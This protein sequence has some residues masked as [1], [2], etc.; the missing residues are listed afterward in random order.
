MT[1]W[2]MLLLCVYITLGVGRVSW[3]KSGHIA[4]VI[5]AVVIAAAVVSYVHKAPV[6]KYIRSVDATVYQTG[7]Q[8]IVPGEI[9]HS[10]PSTEDVTGATAASFD[11]TDHTNDFSP[12]GGGS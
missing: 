11:S 3:R 7:V 5:T 10:T 2:G 8:P 4:F 1:Q 12:G 9:T 6:D